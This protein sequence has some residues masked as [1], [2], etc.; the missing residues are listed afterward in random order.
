MLVRPRLKED[1]WLRAT[2]RDGISEK[3]IVLCRAKGD[4]GTTSRF[5]EEQAAEWWNSRDFDLAELNQRY[6]FFLEQWTSSSKKPDAESNAVISQ[7]L[8]VLLEESRNFEGVFAPSL[9]G[10]DGDGDG[11]HFLTEA[12]EFDNSPVGG[13]SRNT[14][15]RSVQTILNSLPRTVLLG[16]P[17]AGKSTCLRFAATQLAESWSVESP[18]AC[19][20]VLANLVSPGY[21]LRFYENYQRFSGSILNTDSQAES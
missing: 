19:S 3:S 16:E 10:G 2:Q 14:S 8:S 13:R 20:L 6:Q 18:G 5:S 15:S 4:F 9:I 21:G 7:H 17:G 1:R 11:G 12:D